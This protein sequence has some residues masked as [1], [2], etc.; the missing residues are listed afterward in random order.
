MEKERPIYCVCAIIPILNAKL[1][2]IIVIFL[3]FFFE[4][5]VYLKYMHT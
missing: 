1:I 4:E 3:Y 5:L 2:K